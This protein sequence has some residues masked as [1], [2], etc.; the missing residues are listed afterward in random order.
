MDPLTGIQLVEEQHL[1]LSRFEGVQKVE[2]IAKDDY[3][4]LDS[5]LLL[6]VLLHIL[7]HLLH[8]VL[9]LLPL[10][11]VALR[12]S[13]QNSPKRFSWICPLQILF[14]KDW[15]MQLSLEL[16]CPSVDLRDERL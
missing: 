12:S 6:R 7:L 5:N 8:V 4:A 16:A 15:M 1:E 13:R 14:L 10:L 9:L 3:G 11:S 2:T